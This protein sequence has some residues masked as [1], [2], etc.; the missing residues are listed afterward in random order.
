M[1]QEGR[2]VFGDYNLKTSE[3][4]LAIRQAGD[5]MLYFASSDCGEIRDL[6]PARK[7]GIKL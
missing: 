3:K 7:F 2:D 1:N 5:F 4:S 6:V